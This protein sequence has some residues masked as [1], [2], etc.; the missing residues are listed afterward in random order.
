MELWVA[1]MK[2]WIKGV[3]TVEDGFNYWE[4]FLLKDV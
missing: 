2:T 1:V 4:Y 3:W